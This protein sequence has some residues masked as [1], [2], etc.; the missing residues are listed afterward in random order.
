MKDKH[1]RIAFLLGFYILLQPI[2]MVWHAQQHQFKYSS[3]DDLDHVFVTAEN[4]LDCE[5]CTF[6][7]D[8][9]ISIISAIT[10]HFSTGSIV[11]KEKLT[12]LVYS[13]SS[14]QNYLRG[15]PTIE[16]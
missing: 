14:I 16:I 15:P 3:N 10:H 11:L 6:Y 7:F 8:Q 4:S 1:P 9:P 12:P 2:A 13:Y 5:I